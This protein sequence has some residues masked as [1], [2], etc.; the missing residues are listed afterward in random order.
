MRRV[1]AG[2][3]SLGSAQPHHNSCDDLITYELSGRDSPGKSS[4]GRSDMTRYESNLEPKFLGA[5][6]E[7]VDDSFH[8]V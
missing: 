8:E 1:T 5:C 7:Q 2:P 4:E 3:A 6:A